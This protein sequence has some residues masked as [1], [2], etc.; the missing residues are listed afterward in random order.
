MRRAAFVILA[1]VLGLTSLRGAPAALAASAPG[2][3]PPPAAPAA[4]TFV[5]NVSWT[6]PA[7][8]VVDPEAVAVNANNGYIPQL[9]LLKGGFEFSPSAE[10]IEVHMAVTQTNTGGGYFNGDTSVPSPYYVY[11]MRWQFTPPGSTATEYFAY[12]L[13]DNTGTCGGTIFGCGPERPFCG[14]GV[15][16]AAGNEIVGNH[17]ANCSISF[18][19]VGPT[20]P[21][22]D[23]P[24]GP[25]NKWTQ[26]VV[27]IEIPFADVGGPDPA[28]G[29]VGAPHGV[30]HQP[31]GVTEERADYFTGAEGN[32]EGNVNPPPNN[33]TAPASD[34]GPDSLGTSHDYDLSTPNPSA[35]TPVPPC[36]G[37]VAAAPTPPPNVPLTA[38][39][40]FTDRL[41]FTHEA[42]VD[43]QRTSGSPAVA[44][45][46]AGG[47]WLTAASGV[48]GGTSFLWKSEDG[49]VQYDALRCQG[50]VDRPACSPGGSST[51]VA[52]GTAQPPGLNPPQPPSA[53]FADAAAPTNISCA[54]SWD[55]GQSMS[56]TGPAPAQPAAAGQACNAAGSTSGSPVPGGQRPWL[57]VYRGHNTQD[58]AYLVYTTAAGAQFLRS[59]D[60]GQ[61]YAGLTSCTRMA[62]SAASSPCAS[63]AIGVNT[64]RA[65]NLVVDQATGSVYAFLTTHDPVTGKYG[66]QVAAT[67][68]APTTTGTVDWY[69]SDIPGSAGVA[70]TENGY[71]AGAID[72]Q[73]NLYVVWVASPDPAVNR[74]QQVVYYSHSTDAGSRRGAR[75]S[76]PVPVTGAGSKLPYVNSTVF[77]WV[78]AGDPG[79]VDIAF[80]GTEHALPYNASVDSARWYVDFVQT[81]DGR[82]ASPRF[83]P[84]EATPGSDSFIPGHASEM[85]IHIGSICTAAS[86]CTPQQ[87]HNLGDYIQMVVNPDG[88]ADIVF[89]DDNNSAA[90]THAGAPI[91][92]FIR[93]GTGHSALATTNNGLGYVL[94][95]G[96][97]L[98]QSLDVRAQVLD[99]QGDAL[100]PAHS[101]G[102]ATAPPH[103]YPAQ[104]LAAVRLAPK[105][106]DMLDVAITT[107]GGVGGPTYI[108]ACLANY[109]FFGSSVCQGFVDYVV[110]WHFNNDIYYTG[111]RYNFANGIPI[112]P[113]PLNPNNDCCIP[114]VPQ[115]PM[116]GKPT[117]IPG[118]GAPLGLQYGIGPGA[119]KIDALPTKNVTGQTEFLVP[120]ALIGAPKRGDVL[121]SVQAFT[122]FNFSIITQ[123]QA[124]TPYG[125]LVDAT[126][127]I[128]Y[129]YG[130]QGAKLTGNPPVL[131][132]VGPPTTFGRAIPPLPATAAPMQVPFLAWGAL[133]LGVPAT[134]GLGREGLRRR[135]R[136]RRATAGPT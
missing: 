15:I 16:D 78:A 33:P 118:P 105:G 101:P 25:C 92:N 88:G 63:N 110:V 103:M 90:S 2:C 96:P 125:G 136:R 134:A 7:C 23:G 55:G 80:L 11:E 6:D 72:N 56:V 26:G 82:T 4:A 79:R 87:N 120:N 35:P 29:P 3:T 69:A 124:P 34:T 75:W 119:Q 43:V 98:S 8:D 14:D 38:N 9:D 77:P 129:A 91:V 100:F 20:G 93:Q 18:P 116:A 68:N 73:G 22:L 89:V 49:G 51:A 95:P 65:G 81:L 52:T 94:N 127:P 27:T 32:G 122:Y 71:A 39:D 13:I 10:A 44:I 70:S 109:A 53:Y 47:Y 117:S 135:R 112:L 108:A 54:F 17:S 61:T 107:P 21:K 114:V 102:N 66:V 24:P 36:P 131:Q 60:S 48:P 37:G 133:A 86:S 58:T 83:Q 1:V 67:S 30:L 28:K 76:N 62:G 12:A 57:A 128:D 50:Q 31:Y 111:V 104:D 74:T 42:A 84:A 97:E 123:V 121:R 115:D 132:T 130:L 113:N 5:G 106:K 40:I 46:P 59:V 41:L 85:P 45:D 126:P 99:P 64:S 19:P